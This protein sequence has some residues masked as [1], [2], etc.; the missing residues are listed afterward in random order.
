M[1]KF[2]KLSIYMVAVLLILSMAA[3]GSATTQ[4][5]GATSAQTSATTAAQTSATTTK[6]ETTTEAKQDKADIMTP[7]GKYDKPIIVTTGIP[8]NTSV[9]FAEGQSQTDNAYYD[10]LREELNIDVK[11]LWVSDEYTNK[12][13]LSIASGDIPDM[14]SLH[15]VNDYTTFINLMQNDMLADLKESVEKCSNDLLKA[16]NAANDNYNIEAFTYDGKLLAYASPQL[17][18]NYNRLW[19]R[20]DWLDKLN[21]PVPK[22]VSDIANTARAFIDSDAGGTGD[23]LGLL[24]HAKDPVGKVAGGFQCTPIFWSYGAFPK[25]WMADSDGK[26]YYGSTVPEMKEGLSLLAQWYKDGVIDK[27]FMTRIQTGETNA[28]RD[29]NQAGIYFNSDWGASTQQHSVN[30][31]ETRWTA[32]LAPL[33]GEGKFPYPKNAPTGGMLCVRKGYEHPEAAIKII[34][35]VFEVHNLINPDYKPIKEKM[36]YGAHWSAAY[37]TGGV[38]PVFA[39]EMLTTSLMF[40]DYIDSD[41]DESVLMNTEARRWLGEHIRVAARDALTYVKTENKTVETKGYPWYHGYYVSGSIS[42]NP[43]AQRITPAFF[44]VTES[45]QT[46]KPSL[47]TMEDEAYLRIIVGEDPVSAF[48]DFVAQ[49]R[50]LGGDT[51]IKEIQAAV[52]MQ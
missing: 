4:S 38:N 13:S 32:T 12:L 34:N 37:P 6:S 44:S 52:D 49:W 7:N 30:F 47:D 1:K 16:T 41:G 42:G 24:L 17:Q 10:L 35:K 36:N 19:V 20:Q 33:N 26:I 18:Y 51:L 11:I 39:D 31:P 3:C 2:T 21:L 14:F 5:G 29:N 22:T 15:S 9:I 40:K 28:V 45:F 50:S 48:D 27:S 8:L 43:E 46:I 25:Q 23:T